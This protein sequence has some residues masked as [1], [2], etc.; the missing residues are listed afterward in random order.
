[1]AWFVYLVRCSDGSL[2]AGCTNDL[3]KRLKTHNAGR[4][5]RYT[6]SRGPVALVWSRK[7]QG[8]SAALRAEAKIKR[9]TRAEKLL[10]VRNAPTARA[11]NRRSRA[12]KRHGR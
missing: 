10:L 2:Y 9:Q 11:R 7:V 8:R 6:R 3:V 1:M 4:G 12:Q 5:A